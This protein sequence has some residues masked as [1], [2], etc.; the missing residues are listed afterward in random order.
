MDRKQSFLLD[1]FYQWINGFLL[2]RCTT[3]LLHTV[4]KVR[5]RWRGKISSSSRFLFFRFYWN[6]KWILLE[7]EPLHSLLYNGFPGSIAFH[8]QLANRLFF[9]DLCEL[10]SDCILNYHHL[11]LSHIE[12]WKDEEEKNFKWRRSKLTSNRKNLLTFNGRGK[13]SLRFLWNVTRVG[14]RCLLD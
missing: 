3:T 13:E 12:G 9:Y 6:F 2:C 14:W 11:L 7:R 10:A 4:S 1:F 5:K 8:C